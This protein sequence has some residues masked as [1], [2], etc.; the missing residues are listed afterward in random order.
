MA[1]YGIYLMTFHKINP[2]ANKSIQVYVMNADNLGGFYNGVGNP[3]DASMFLN[4]HLC[5]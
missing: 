3:P 1:L 2:S 5:W 4:A